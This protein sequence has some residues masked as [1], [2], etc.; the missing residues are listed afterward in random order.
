M[1]KGNTQM[2]RSTK[3]AQ[4]APASAPAPAEAP[5]APIADISGGA[6]TRYDPTTDCVTARYA[7]RKTEGG[8]KY[9]K[10]TVFDFNNIDRAGLISLAMYGVRVKAQSILRDMDETMMAD[11]KTFATVNVLERIINTT[12]AKADPITKAL[13][14]LMNTGL[15]EAAA[16]AALEAGLK[17]QEAS[18]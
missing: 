13:K 5:A 6:Y 11:P 10:E 15:S 2:A 8:K 12:R 18:Q 9:V 1:E 7:I 17:V 14:A 3:K 16:K 4:V